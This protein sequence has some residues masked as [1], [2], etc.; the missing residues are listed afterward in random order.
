MENTTH[1]VRSKISTRM[2]SNLILEQTAILESYS[3]PQNLNELDLEKIAKEVNTSKDRVFRWFQRK[4]YRKEGAP[5]NQNPA[6]QFH[7][8]DML[9]NSTKSILEQMEDEDVLQLGNGQ[10]TSIN[11][12][13]TETPP[14]KA[15]TAYLFSQEQKE[16]LIEFYNEDS[17][18][19]RGKKHMIAEVIG[20][21]AEKV[22]TWW[23][24]HRRI[25]QKSDKSQPKLITEDVMALPAPSTDGTTP[26]S[27]LATSFTQFTTLSTTSL[28][29]L[30]GP[31][32]VDKRRIFSDVHIDIMK[33]Y[34]AEN[35][36]NIESEKVHQFA[37][38]FGCTPKQVHSWFYRQ[39]DKD[40]LLNEKR[41]H[42]TN[43][44]MGGKMGRKYYSQGQIDDLNEY[45]KQ[46]STLRR[47]VSSTNA[48]TIKL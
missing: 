35:P 44:G 1:L 32:P 4:K 36:D 30:P 37:A 22:L 48:L 33:Q 27:T 25:G 24:N 5:T 17:S 14:K 16:K 9:N 19:P 7:P 31:Q 23:M 47:G 18:M 20:A 39:R 26:S 13:S 41:R 38:E 2:V 43:Y 11:I 46:N 10:A 34:Y 40:N 15:Y 6:V 3:L 42:G 45:F 28:A 21:P 12:P 8:E 29:P